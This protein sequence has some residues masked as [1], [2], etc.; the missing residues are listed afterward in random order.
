[1]SDLHRTQSQSVPS[2]LSGD[3]ERFIDLL[4][5]HRTQLLGYLFCVVQNMDDAEDLFQQV[6][7]TLWD[8]FATFEPGSSFA[9]WAITVA[10]NKAMTFMRSKRRETSRFSQRVVDELSLRDLWSPMDAD[11]RMAALQSCQKKLPQDDQFLLSQCYG[12]GAKTADVARR[13]GRPVD[14][15]YTSLSRIRRVLFTCIKRSLAREERV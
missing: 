11:D 4:Q 12:T 7:I 5:K 15:V 13:L 1:M 3:D 14:S 10:R 6:S 8:K 9:A 2:S